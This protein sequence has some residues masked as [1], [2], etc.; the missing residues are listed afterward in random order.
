M[1]LR[2]ARRFFPLLLALVGTPLHAEPCA[3]PLAATAV[4]GVEQCLRMRQF[5][6]ET[7]ETFIVWLHGDVSS[8]GPANYHFAIAEKATAE[9]GADTARSVALVRP[10]YP[11]GS[12]NESGVAFGHGGRRDHYTDVNLRELAAAIERLKA[13]YAPKRTVLVGHSG[14]AASAAVLLGMA[15]GLADSAVLVACPCDLGVWRASRGGGAWSRSE[16]PS[17]WIGKVAPSTRVIALTGE[18]DDNTRPQLAEA[19]V[20][21][22]T[23][24]GV[25]ARFA[26]LPYADHN[27][28]FRAPEVTL[29]LRE[30]LTTPDAA[31]AAKP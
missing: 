28:A 11:D 4:S 3:E 9:L 27:S 21:A 12:G 25:Q 10:G 17:A 24:Q 22:L 20:K 6:S 23:A 26:A 13:R 1:P 31:P 16:N 2:L 8:G 19:Y 15:P 29:A 14:G 7:P 5:G 18:R 30:L